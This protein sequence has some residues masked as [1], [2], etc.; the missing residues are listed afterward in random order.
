MI[1]PITAGGTG[2]RHLVSF[3]EEKVTTLSSEIL[4]ACERL[5][6]L[7]RMPRN[8]FIGN[9]HLVASAKYH[10]IVG[11][12]AAIDL[13]NHLISQ[14]RWRAPVDYADTFRIME[15]HGFFDGELSSRL[16]DMARFRNRIIHL[17]WNIDNDM[18][19]D[20]LRADIRDIKQFL[21]CYLRKIRE[22]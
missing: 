11:I 2:G 13:S 15:Q 1:L 21:D 20:V 6:E 18:I 4:S 19:Y 8:E 5:R 10:L 16:Q 22:P 14:N 12:E 9:P 7:G 3:D 17:Y